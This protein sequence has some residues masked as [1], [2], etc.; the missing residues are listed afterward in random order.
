MGLK[1]YLRAPKRPKKVPKRL[2]K[3]VVP[4]T[5]GQMVAQEASGGLPDS[6]WTAPGLVLCS[7]MDPV[8]EFSSIVS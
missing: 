8:F 1:I 2:K 5:P 6:F 4:G 3:K 7:R